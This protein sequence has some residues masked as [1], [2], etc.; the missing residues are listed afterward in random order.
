MLAY[1]IIGIAL[2]AALIIGGKSLANA[3]PK[4]II[5]AFRI[6]GAII[7]GALAAFFA[8]TGRFQIA[9][10]LA[11]I[12]LFLLRKKPLFGRST[13]SS[14]Q[15]SEV[16]TDWLYAILDHDSGE[17]DAEIL[18]GEFMGERL[19]QLSLQ[20]LQE[21]SRSLEEDE[22]SAAILVTFIERNFSDSEDTQGTDSGGYSNHTQQTGMSRTEA[23]EILEL[24]PAANEADIKASHKRLM[25]KFHPD[26]DGSSYMAA[27]LNQAK[28]VLLKS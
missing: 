16:T 23:F 11:L 25:K 1:F 17:M 19:S 27:K 2:L 18:Q 20:Q 12:A 5:R 24:D 3:E 28:E 15:K 22:Q 8:Y 9:P 4:H 10:P 14:G 6:A 26:H 7:L 21:L 13:P